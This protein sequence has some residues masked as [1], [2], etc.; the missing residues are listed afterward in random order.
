MGLQA[1]T[2]SSPCTPSRLAA[3]RSVGLSTPTIISAAV[4][5]NVTALLVRSPTTTVTRAGPSGSVAGTMVSMRSG[6]PPE[7]LVTPVTS[8]STPAKKTEFSAA[9]EPKLDPMRVVAD[10]AGPHIVAQ[11]LNLRGFVERAG[12]VVRLRARALGAVDAVQQRGQ[13]E[14]HVQGEAA[15]SDLLH[16]RSEQGLLPDDLVIDR[17]PVTV[18]AVQARARTRSRAR[19]PKR[20][21]QDPRLGPGHLRRL[22]G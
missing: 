18:S 4:T 5:W 22:L 19:Y 17:L 15:I 7:P 3:R 10:P 20:Q 16:Q 2:R 11:G 1:T 13:Q 6:S 9:D 8:A 12:E 21:G 14:Q